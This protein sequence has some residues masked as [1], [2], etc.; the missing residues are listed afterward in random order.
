[1]TDFLNKY[2]FTP[3]F[4]TQF[5]ATIVGIGTSIITTIITLRI[6]G[7]RE[8][9]AQKQIQD[10]NIQ[11]ATE[12]FRAYVACLL[13]FHKSEYTSEECSS[14]LTQCQKMENIEQALIK[15]NTNDFPSPFLNTLISFQVR[16]MLLRTSLV[17][18]LSESYHSGA[19][20]NLD[21]ADIHGL[22]TE[23]AEFIDVSSKKPED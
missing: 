5:F 13:A 17:S 20:L 8:A 21:T 23:L 6:Q 18:A 1:M 11:A 16:I 4:F 19:P 7:K 15:L 10:A 14:L 22:I 9:Q 12:L 3:G 2:I